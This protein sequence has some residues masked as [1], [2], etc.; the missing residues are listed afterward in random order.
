MLEPHKEASTAEPIRRGFVPQRLVI[1]MRQHRGH[2]AEPVVRVGEE[3]LKGQPIGRAGHTLSA[4]VHASSSGRITAI[5][6]RLVP[7][8]RRLHPAL[9]VCIETDGLDRPAGRAL[10]W[11]RDRE[12]R[13]RAL[14]NAGIS[15][16][17]G[18]AYPTADK[19]ATG[20]VAGCKALIIN[21]AECEPYISCDDMLMREQ[22]P[23]ILHGALALADL[24]G[25]P[26]VIIAVEAD[27]PEAFEAVKHAATELEEPRLRLCSVPSVYP[28]G[29]ERQLIALLT[30]EE[31]PSGRY[32]AEVGYPC[33]NV[34][35]AAAVG[36]LAAE[37]APLTTRIVTVAGGGVAGARNVEVPIG[38][39]VGDLIAFCG[40]YVEPVERLLLGGAMMGYA[41]ANDD[42]P[43]TKATNC[44]VAA[45]RDEVY[46][47]RHEWA[48]IRC[49]ACA[50]ACPVRLMPQDLFVAARADD[51]DALGQLALK[52]CIE[53]GCCDVVCPSH[54]PLVEHF[55][56]AKEAVEA[57]HTRAAFAAASQERSQRRA[58]RQQ[59]AEQADRTRQ[60]ALLDELRSP[61]TRYEA[62]AA[63]IARAKRHRDAD[64][65][66]R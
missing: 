41:L 52:D 43:V 61:A 12:S 55:R 2:A 32:P 44:I 27:K 23:Q 62:L 19:I 60:T 46:S 7:G 45:S 40:G 58:A 10:D 22:A 57:D 53:C 5:E 34:G 26:T 17:G 24:L 49:G 36:R 18:A 6:Q 8:G 25:A 59:A 21:G 64:T 30:G 20:S 42:I 3:V 48:C 31:V 28:T 65:S 66:E 54:I 29:A 16:L 35:T 4:A 9:C 13:I 11:P 37:G 33:Q 38:T 39:V 51:I 14:R 47:R 56:R 1:A 15:G 50:H 63:A